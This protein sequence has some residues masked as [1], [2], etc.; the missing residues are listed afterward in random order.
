M[1]LADDRARYMRL[2]QDP[3]WRRRSIRS[4]AVAIGCSPSTI[5]AWERQARAEEAAAVDVPG[6]EIIRRALQDM[7]D[8]ALAAAARYR[9][10]QLPV[11]AVVDDARQFVRD[12]ERMLDALTGDMQRAPDVLESIRRDPRGVDVLARLRRLMTPPQ[13]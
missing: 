7:D 10:H 6:A 2:R 11:P 4:R 5:V 9:R 1:T 12:V 13:P 3:A 8:L